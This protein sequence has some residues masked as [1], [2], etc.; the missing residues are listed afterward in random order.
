MTVQEIY[1]IMN[2]IAPFSESMD[3][4]NTGLLIG[5]PAAQVTRVL[6]CLDVTKAVLK[7]AVACG[8]ELIISHHP[9]IFHPLRSLRKGDRAYEIVQSGVSVI[10]AH[11]N[12]D[13]AFPFGV[14][15]ALASALGLEN[16]HGV[17]PEGNG[18]IGFMGELSEAMTP[19]AFGERVKAALGRKFVSY[20][21]A[22]K[23]LRKVCVV[24]GAG[25]EYWSA[26]KAFGADAFVTGEVA[27]HEAIDAVESGFVMYEA[28]HYH[29]E[30]LYRDMLKEVLGEKCPDVTFLVSAKECSP[31]EVL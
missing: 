18:Y 9:I 27:Q 6:L 1:D 26:A 22:D 25:G 10:S 16:I 2:E 20:T 21:P 11:T 19:E 28:G 5:D 13:K 23:M 15:H 30:I 14:N 24:G 7:E 3:F 29:T 17:I 12:L 31:M 8:A 4:D